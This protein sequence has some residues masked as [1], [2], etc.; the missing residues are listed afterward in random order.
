[1][2]PHLL[3]FGPASAVGWRVIRRSDRGKL[4]EGCMYQSELD[5][6]YP[7]ERNNHYVA[8]ARILRLIRAAQAAQS[9]RKEPLLVRIFDA[10]RPRRAARA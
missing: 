4:Y 3:A 5:S 8:A 10:L 9:V 1:M 6:Q 2:P 7:R